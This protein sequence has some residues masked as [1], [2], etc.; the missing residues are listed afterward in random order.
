MAL[1]VDLQVPPED[2]ENSSVAEYVSHI[3]PVQKQKQRRRNRKRLLIALLVLLIVGAVAGYFLTKKPSSN[4]QTPSNQSA[5]PEAT[6][7]EEELVTTT[8]HYTSSAF[9]LSLDYPSNWSVNDKE[10][11]TF[12]S[13]KL[14]L[15]NAEGQEGDSLV[16]IM[17]RS[18]GSRVNEIEGDTI[19]AL[20]ASEKIAY[21]T[22]SANQR[23]ETYLTFASHLSPKGLDGIYIT[24][25]NGYEKDA[26]V[27][28][29]DLMLSDPM[30]NV[31]FYACQDTK[32]DL[33]TAQPTG[34]QLDQWKTN[35]YLNQVLDILKSITVS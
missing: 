25:D 13:P 19:T 30:I 27:P 5:Q 32:C 10:G 3:T 17:V 12:V 29:S 1:P 23:A 21:T 33:K 6:E 26:F 7:P 24:G 15:A 2:E 14:K 16:V 35:K 22:P 20:K 34:V 9:R 8:E 28:K 31:S 18:K 11:L 4:E